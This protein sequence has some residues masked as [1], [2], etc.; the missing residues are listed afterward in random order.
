MSYRRF[1]AYQGL[2]AEVLADRSE[3]RSQGLVSGNVLVIHGGL[4][5]DENGVGTLALG[6]IVACLQP[7]RLVDL[8]QKFIQ[9]WLLAFD[10]GF[11]PVDHVYLGLH[12]VYSDHLEPGI[13]KAACYRSSNVTQSDYDDLLHGALTRTS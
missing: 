3:G 13:R 10:R 2:F 9:T 8:L 1:D 7:S 5:H 6:V 12:N 4:D 11:A